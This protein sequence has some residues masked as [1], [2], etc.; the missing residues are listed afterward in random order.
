M[1]T[2]I[3]NRRWSGKVVAWIVYDGCN[4]IFHTGVLG[5]FFP[6]WVTTSQG[7]NDA[8]YGYALA[9][10]MGLVI[11]CSPFI[12]RLYDI[13]WSRYSGMAWFTG[14]SVVLTILLGVLDIGLM[15]GLVLF[16]VALV[17]LTFAELLYN[18]ALA[19][20]AS[21]SEMGV[22]GGLGIG[23]GYLGSVMAVVIGLVGIDYMG[24]TYEFSF[25][26]IGLIMALLASPLV[27]VGMRSSEQ[28]KLLN[29]MH[30]EPS[31]ANGNGLVSFRTLGEAFVVFRIKSVRTFLIARFW[32]LWMVSVGSS[33]GVLYATQT[34]GMTTGDVQLV[35]LAALGL[36]VPSGY[37]WGKAVDR[38]GSIRCLITCLCC[39]FFLISLAIA[40]PVFGLP[41]ATWWIIGLAA[42]S[43]YGAIWVSDRPLVV[44]LAPT[45][46]LNSVFGMYMTV[47]R[48]GYAVG[49]ACWSLVAV[50]FGWGQPA[51]MGVLLICTVIAIGFMVRLLREPYG[52][53]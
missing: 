1:F 28:N 11:L 46:Q 49:S 18:A 26:V 23:L 21:P 33:F 39:W 42:G 41:S 20:V 6:L 7:G 30:I 48:L 47:G 22:I 35:L 34:I 43:F 4:T 24:F 44:T 5:L 15:F 14:I 45:H 50:T 53:E 27:I 2:E 36:A 32:Y 52:Y 8:H 16:G 37:V 10:A 19:D 17:S 25:W 13:R 12:G 51:A 40:V 38:Y 31:K 3:F 29:A 9:A